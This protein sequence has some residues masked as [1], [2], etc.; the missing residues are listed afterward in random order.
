MFVVTLNCRR[1]TRGRLSPQFHIRRRRR[2]T[3]LPLVRSS[4]CLQRVPVVKRPFRDRE[5]RMLLNHCAE[6]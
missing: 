5:V 2:V 1:R 4:I 6:N 3:V